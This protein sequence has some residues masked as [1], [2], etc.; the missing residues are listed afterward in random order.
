MCKCISKKPRIV[1]NPIIDYFIRVITKKAY[2]NSRER[3]MQWLYL[4]K[5]K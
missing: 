5:L 4:N 1:M 2:G 3:M